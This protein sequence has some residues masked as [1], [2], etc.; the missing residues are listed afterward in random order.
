MTTALHA[1]PDI[2]KRPATERPPLPTFSSVEE[3]RLHRKQKLAAA[4]RI[5]AKLG[6]QEGVMGHFSVRDPEQTD[7]YWANPYA[8]DFGAIRASDL[9]LYNFDGQIVEGN[10]RYIHRGNTIL[11]VPILKTR[12]GVIAAAH[13]HAVNGR[14]LSSLGKLLEP[15]SAES[16]VFYQR[17]AIY[18]SYKLGEGYTLANAIGD[19]RA[20]ILKSHGILTVGQSVDEAAYLFISMERAAQAQLLAAAAGTPQPIEHEHALEISNRFNSYIGWLNFQPLFQSIVRE[21]P[22]LLL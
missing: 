4:F 3:E 16:A 19:N 13:T 5:F 22:D 21:Q 20:L 18:D 12:P 14:A 8:T 6:Y 7:H 17:H 9:V 15:L 1:I 11:H 2:A 10:V